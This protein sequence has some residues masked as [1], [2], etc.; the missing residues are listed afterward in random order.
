MCVC[1]QCISMANR[2]SNVGEDEVTSTLKEEEGENEVTLTLEQEEGENEVTLTFEQEEG[3]NEVTLTLEQEEG[4]NEVTLTLEQEEGENE[5]TLTFEQEEGKNE[6]TP[7]SEQEKCENEVTLT[8]DQEEG[9]N[10]GTPTLEQAGES[11]GT[12][13]PKQEEGED[14][15]TPFLEQEG[16]DSRET[17]ASFIANQAKEVFRRGKFNRRLYDTYF[18]TIVLGGNTRD[19][20]S[21]VEYMENNGKKFEGVLDWLLKGTG[22]KPEEHKRSFTGFDCC[23]RVLLTL[24]YLFVMVIP[25]FYIFHKLFVNLMARR[26]T[27]TF[28]NIPLPLMYVICSQNKGMW[29]YFVETKQVS[30]MDCD[31]KG[32]NIFHH[33]VDMSVNSPDQAVTLFKKLIEFMNNINSVK[34]LVLDESNDAGLSVLEY[35]GKYGSSSL[36]TE[37]LKYPNLLAHTVLTVK[38]DGRTVNDERVPSEGRANLSDTSIDYVDVSKYE[39]GELMHQ[40]AFLNLLSDR[41]F[42]MMSSDELKIFQRTAFVGKWMVMKVNPDDESH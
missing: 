2:T 21:V 10:E 31:Y 29:K 22:M 11:E 39:C 16:G 30:V 15:S 37:M 42:M 35:A 33:I 32:N 23:I 20:Q 24:H 36:I 28:E 3:E 17:Y 26:E 18:Y 7:T 27:R 9:E 13:T 12:P 40:S 41:C 5:V 4:E 38:D 1:L 8:L 14:E 6:G 34:K 19:V 25:L